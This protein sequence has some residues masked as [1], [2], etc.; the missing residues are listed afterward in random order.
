MKGSGVS[1]VARFCILALAALLPV[2]ALADGMV[3]PQRAFAIPQIPD[4]QALLHY[5]NGTETLVIETAFVGQGTNF[6]W[7]VPLPA[8]AKIEPASTGL[9]PTLQTIFQ[10]EVVLSVKHYWIALPIAAAVL[11]MV[12]FIRREPVF[13]VLV[14]CLLILL[15]AFLL[16]PALATAKSRASVAGSLASQV[17]VLN[18][19]TAGLFD[20]VTLKSTTPTA[21]FDW[22]SE[23]GFSTPTNMAPVVADYIRAGWVFVAARLHD[24]A[25]EAKARATHPLVFTFPTPKP[26]YPLRLTAMGAFSCSID[27][28]VF[29]PGRAQARGFAVQRCEAPDYHAQQQWPRMQAGALQIRHPDLRKVVAEAPVATKLTATLSPSDMAH[30]AYVSWAPYLPAGQKVYSPG[31]ALTLSS[32]VSALLFMALV[33]GWWLLRNAKPAFQAQKWGPR[34]AP[35]AFAAGVAVYFL[36]LPK[37]GGMSLRTV[38]VGSSS[39]RSD[40]LELAMALGDELTDTNL[41]ANAATPARPLR[42]GEVER[43]FRAAARDYRDNWAQY[44]SR[45]SPLTNCFTGEPIRFEASPGNVVLRPAVQFATIDATTAPR[46]VTNGYELVWHDLDGAE[47]IVV[48]VPP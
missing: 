11:W 45:R 9:F 10:P 46:A 17:R 29:G 34:L 2:A 47:A 20:T 3:I 23:S 48:P 12:R 18:R 1:V 27:L 39:V 41:I 40:A 13:G 32:N 25:G 36:A 42:P 6:A 8:E 43:L 30:D 16:L 35:I 7:V 26:V 38:R 21:L 31:A 5:A 33:M 19:Q 4:Q 24:D 37:V 22:L 14:L 44:S 15:L 28:Y